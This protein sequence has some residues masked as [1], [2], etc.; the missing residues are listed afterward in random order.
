M[1]LLPHFTAK[2]LEEMA[3]VHTC[4]VYTHTNVC[5]QF[6]NLETWTEYQVT[7][8]SYFLQIISKQKGIFQITLRDKTTVALSSSGYARQPLR[9][10]SVL[11]LPPPFLSK[12]AQVALLLPAENLFLCN[13]LLPS[14]HP[15]Q[16]LAVS[17]S[18]N[19]LLWFSETEAGCS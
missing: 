8:P 15:M 17:R 14:P 5:K 13:G 4:A 19:L 12:M 9:L 16:L 2:N 3:I 1:Y 6:M 10:K 18:F 7:N 11:L